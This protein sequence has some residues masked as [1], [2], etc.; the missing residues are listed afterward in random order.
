MNKTDLAI[1]FTV[2]VITLAIL[3]IIGSYAWGIVE[4]M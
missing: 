1:A 3:T 2:F 4:A